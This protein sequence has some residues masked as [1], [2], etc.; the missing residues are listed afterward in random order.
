[1]THTA[2]NDAPRKLARCGL[3]FEHNWHT[4]SDMNDGRW[5]VC[6]GCTR[7]IPPVVGKP[8]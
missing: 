7:P 8:S 4:Y 1:M 3:D 6:D 2:E 5:H